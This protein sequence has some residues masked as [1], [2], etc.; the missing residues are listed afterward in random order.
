MHFTD[1]LAALRARRRMSLAAVG[2]IAGMAVPNLSTVLRGRGGDTKASTLESIASALDATWLLVPNEYVE[3][4]KRAMES[5]AKRV[6]APDAPQ[7]R[8]I[9]ISS[10]KK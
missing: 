2:E 5:T 3:A 4:A 9:E 7:R 6:I 8:T 1:Q 10:T